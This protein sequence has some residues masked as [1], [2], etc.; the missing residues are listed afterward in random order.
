MLRDLSQEQKEIVEF[1]GNC[2]VIACPGSGK[3][4][5][6]VAK[7]AYEANRI[8][9]NT[10]I[11]A[12]TYTNNAANEISSRLEELGVDENSYWAGTIHSFCLQ[13]ILHPFA[14]L[15]EETRY[16]YVIIDDEKSKKIKDEI[17][18]NIKVENEI[19]REY[20]KRLRELRYVD[21]ELIL[22]YS[23]E[24]LKKNLHIAKNISTIFQ[25]ILVDEYQDTKELQYLIIGEI[26]KSR[27]NTTKIM[28]VG[29]PN[30]AIFGSLGGVAKQKDEIKDCIGGYEVEEKFLTGNYRSSKNIVNFFKFF[31]II[32]KNTEAIGKY[33][34]SNSII[35]FEDQT[36]SKDKLPV[37][38]GNLINELH[39]NNI[40]YNEIC[41][42]ASKWNNLIEVARAIH[43]NFP[44]IP[45]DVPGLLPIVKDENNIFFHFARL[46][47]VT[48]SPD[49]IT[50]R[51]KW[52]NSLLK[53]LETVI[54]NIINIVP[55]GKVLLRIINK[56]SCDE[57]DGLN[58]LEQ[59]FK[60]IE[61]VLGIQYSDYKQLEQSLNSFMDGCRARIKERNIESSIHYFRQAFRNNQGVVFTTVHSCKGLEYD[62]VI[63]FGLLWGFIPHWDDIINCSNEYSECI[64][65]KLL[66]VICSRAK[67]NIYL[68]SE[69][70][71]YTQKGNTYETNH[72]LKEIWCNNTKSEV[73]KDIILR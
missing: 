60:Y 20:K 4:R 9:F 47:L 1:N 30:Q 68:I 19:N 42:I 24:I 32:G 3:T 37:Y 48:P 17:S 10:K 6:L 64:S 2:L 28:F 54:P 8:P 36:I 7:I 52:A 39:K 14:G 40:P 70:G 65:K 67:R 41:V 16:G 69:S 31:Q 29:D 11:A 18:K 49:L 12:I 59:G 27:E 66:Y 22:V 72:H 34:E 21:F 33:S 61:S 50:L 58:Y 25:W 56:F 15:L 43:Q 38:I 45:L 23:L 46:F 5:T 73:F 63:A 35:K 53:K 44:S 55:N 26:I 13:W 51:I 71:R 57:I 62:T